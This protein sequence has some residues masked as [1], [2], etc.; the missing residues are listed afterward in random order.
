[1]S[2]KGPAGGYSKADLKITDDAKKRFM[3][4]G[5]SKNFAAQSRKADSSDSALHTDESFLDS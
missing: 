3:R 1:M 5:T 4:Q 2:V